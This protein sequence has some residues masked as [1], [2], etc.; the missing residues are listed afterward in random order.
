M[1][2]RCNERSSV[3]LLTLSTERNYHKRAK[4]S[5]PNLT[6]PPPFHPPVARGVVV[7]DRARAYII[8]LDSSNIRTH[9][10][11]YSCIVY[12]TKSRASLSL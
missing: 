3:H 7:E 6:P 1:R 10:H 8:K 9:T 5:I 2:G 4:I 11:A 12:E